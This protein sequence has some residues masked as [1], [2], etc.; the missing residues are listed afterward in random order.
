MGAKI[1]RR[2]IHGG[3][4]TEVKRVTLDPSGEP[5]VK[6]TVCCCDVPGGTRKE[7]QLNREHP[8][9]TPCRCWC[10]SDKATGKHGH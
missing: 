10:H 2:E 4:W 6:Q 1:T 3:M 5:Y 7:C 8:I 9:K